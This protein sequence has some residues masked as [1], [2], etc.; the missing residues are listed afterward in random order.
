LSILARA[1]CL[2]CSLLATLTASAADLRGIYVYTNDVSKISK[3][4]ATAITS[5]LGIPGMDGVAIVIGWGAIEPSLG[6]YQWTTL[7]SWLTQATASGKKIELVVMAGDST[8]SWLFQSV[9]AGGAGAT[10]LNFTISPHGGATGQCQ[11]VTMAPPWDAAF[12]AQWDAMLVALS[13]HLKSVGAYNA[14]TLLRITGINRTT[15]ELRIPAETAQSTGLSCVTDAIATWQQAGYKPS[16][17]LQGWNAIT[18]SFLK[19]FP[20]KALSIAIIPQNAFPPIAEDGTIIKG[21][22]P[23][24]NQPLISLA[25]QKFTGRL[26]VQFDFLMPGE[27]ASPTV[28]G[29]AQSLGTLAAFQTN[30]YLGQ[31]GGGAACSEPVTN[32]TPCTAQTFSALLQT[33][34]FPLG[35]VNPLRAQYIE[36]FQANANAFPGDI[37]GAHDDLFPVAHRRSAHH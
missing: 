32:P 35:V 9:S 4:T 21:T 10:Q 20:D 18:A 34:I 27:A 25:N 5:A 6:Q 22:P 31:T 26:V 12:L 37:L 24:A 3:P 17:L 1:A 15:D 23:D 13:A 19:T 36:V 33:G 16:L 7:D 8:P 14:I 29:Y 2:A 28:V 11:S 30:E